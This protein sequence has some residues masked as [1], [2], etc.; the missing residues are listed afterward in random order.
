M[1]KKQDWVVRDKLVFVGLEDAKRTW[2]L[3][4]RSEG[5]VVHETSL[6]AEYANLHQYLTRRYPGCRIRV[7]YEAGFSGFGLHDRLVADG[8]GC[9][10][11]PPH[12]VTQEKVQGVKTDR[13]DARRLARNLESGDYAACHVPDRER[14]E[15]RQLVRTLSQIQRDVVRTKNRIRKFLDF[16]GLNAGL[17][18]GAWCRSDYARLEAMSLSGPLRQS[19]TVWLRQLATLEDL[20]RELVAALKV[21]ASKARYRQAVASKQRCAGVG[22][23]SAIRFTLEWGDL[24]RFPTGKQIASFVG[25]TSREHSSG[26]V[27]HRGRITGQGNAQ[28]RA[29]L[30]QCAWRALRRDPVLLAKYQ[31]VWRN[32]G[33][34]KKAIV[35]VARTLAVRMRAV[36]LANEPYTPGVIR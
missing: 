3:C 21:V 36:E 20:K 31:R 26:E 27:V 16:H 19:L 30:I 2:K 22:W 34:K 29:W 24:S 17:P 7:M 1:R 15:D 5:M 4:V 11:T 14:R 18:V 12:T 23:L 13:V 6:P 28:V 10:V 9:V 32:A 35:A 33:S 8:I 25:L